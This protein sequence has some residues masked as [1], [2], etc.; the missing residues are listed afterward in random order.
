MKPYSYN[1]NQ[2]IGNET[3]LQESTMPVV[4]SSELVGELR[5]EQPAINGD[6]FL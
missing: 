4:E 3:N 1:K 5:L 6:N 2:W